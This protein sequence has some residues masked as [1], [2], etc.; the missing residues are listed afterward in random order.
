MILPQGFGKAF[1][2]QCSTLMRLTDAPQSQKNMDQK[3]IR[4]VFDPDVLTLV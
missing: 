1:E 4:G 3:N 2:Y